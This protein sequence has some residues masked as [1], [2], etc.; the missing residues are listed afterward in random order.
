MF[1]KNEGIYT[2]N[3]R[4]LKR[5]LLILLLFISYNTVAQDKVIEFDAG[6]ILKHNQKTQKYEVDSVFTLCGKFIISDI[7][8]K[9]IEDGKP[10]FSYM[11][12]GV[13]YDKDMKINFYKAYSIKEDTRIVLSFDDHTVNVGV[14]DGNTFYIYSYLIKTPKLPYDN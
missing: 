6:F 14:Q 10:P 8:I 11:R 1:D 12:E 5:I 9:Y 2:F 4:S 7:D 3:W 13:E